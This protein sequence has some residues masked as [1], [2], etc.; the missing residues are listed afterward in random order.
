MVDSPPCSHT[1]DLHIWGSCSLWAPVTLQ[2]IHTSTEK[3]FNRN[4]VKLP[5]WVVNLCLTITAP[6]TITI[7]KRQR[8]AAVST[9]ITAS[10]KPR[11]DRN[12]QESFNTSTLTCV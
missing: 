5:A 4:F 11:E 8:N 10:S 6:I 2:V 12:V 1:V 7:T 3:I 9:A